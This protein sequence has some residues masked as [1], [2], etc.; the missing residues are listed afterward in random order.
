MMSTSTSST[1]TPPALS[2][3]LV[4]NFPDAYF[5]NEHEERAMKAPFHALQISYYAELSVLLGVAAFFIQYFLSQGVPTVT[6]SNTLID[7]QLCQVLSPRRDVFYF[8]KQHS[9]NAQFASPYLNFTECVTYVSSQKICEDGNR[10]DHMSLLGVKNPNVSLFVDTGYV[11]FT[12]TTIVGLSTSLDIF[13][14]ESASFP[15]P[16][17]TRPFY[18]DDRNWFVYSFEKGE[19]SEFPGTPTSQ[20]LHDRAS[21][22]VYFPV[23]GKQD[24]D[25]SSS[26]SFSVSNDRTY[27]IGKK[28]GNFHVA[29]VSIFDGT[30]FALKTGGKFNFPLS[31]AVDINGDAVLSDNDNSMIRKV[32][33]ATGHVENLLELDL[34]VD[35]KL[36][37]VAVS[38]SNSSIVYYST[39]SQVWK[40]DAA[41]GTSTELGLLGLTITTSFGGILWLAAD[42]ADN[43]VVSDQ[44]SNL[45]LRINATTDLVEDIG[46]AADPPFNS[47]KGVAID[48]QG[49]IYV[50]DYY[51]NDIRIIH[52]NG[53]VTG[54][55]AKGTPMLTSP[56]A[57]A[58][59]TE[60]DIYFLNW[61]YNYVVKI[62][63]SSGLLSILGQS[64]KPAWSIGSN[65]GI[66]VDTEGNVYVTD[67]NL[68]RKI[69]A[70]FGGTTYIGTFVEPEYFTVDKEGEVSEFIGLN[71]GYVDVAGTCQ[72][73]E[74]N[75]SNPNC[76][77][78]FTR[79]LDAEK[80][81]VYFELIKY[82][83]GVQNI[84]FG[85][86]GL[87]VSTTT[88][89][90][91]RRWLSPRR[92][93]GRKKSFDA[94]CCVTKQPIYFR[95]QR[96]EAR[97]Q[98][99]GL[100]SATT[101]HARRAPLWGAHSVSVIFCFSV[102]G[103]AKQKITTPWLLNTQ[104]AHVTFLDP[105]SF[106][107]HLL[108]S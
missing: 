7:G 22:K 91:Q 16:D 15:R 85:P 84:S 34:E 50:A 4:R 100:P 40:L 82:V 64:A 93:E 13:F 63:A 74:Q 96:P 69:S 78:V 80:Q 99:P 72:G 26:Q 60:F 47:P 61:E 68:V 55:A 54:Q 27:R 108:P 42:G 79:N 35:D 58:V 81:T 52:I 107:N 21:N 29:I 77:V 19:F 45:V 73:I 44:L 51:N 36:Y 101:H 86:L 53:S 66:A 88:R 5:R 89:F 97:R 71:F 14:H 67:L 65:A 33:H 41:T 23:A 3:I 11:A 48:S 17:M 56:V 105:S 92:E 6:I 28:I 103:R 46:T 10:N 12:P 75:P 98:G 49:L 95:G 9:E 83:K 32:D 20:L 2:T 102:S 30:I 24:F 62:E 104:L 38:Q 94:R 43:I 76:N 106:R 39:V 8:S 37:S 57:V 70:P 1:T 87:L 59:S 18:D 25:F 31:V 90:A